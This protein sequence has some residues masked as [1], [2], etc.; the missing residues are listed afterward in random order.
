LL[1]SFLCLIKPIKLSRI[2]SFRYSLL[3]DNIMTSQDMSFVKEFTLYEE[4]HNITEIGLE[5]LTNITRLHLCGKDIS[6]TCLLKLTNITELH[7][8]NFVDSIDDEVLCQLI[9]I[10]HLDMCSNNVI[11][12]DGIKNLTNLM[13]LDLDGNVNITD[14]GL[15]KLINLEGLSLYEN[16]C[17]TSRAIVKR[18]GIPFYDENNMIFKIKKLTLFNFQ[19]SKISNS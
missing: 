19:L 9:N 2:N 7:I 17:I 11:T 6:G 1:Y 4:N 18:Q 5:K 3:M 16:R 8:N 13:I 15:D 14:R 10:T 12:D